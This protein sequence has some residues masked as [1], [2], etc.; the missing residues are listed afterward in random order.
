M[1]RW[2]RRKDINARNRIIE[3]YMPLVAAMVYQIAGRI[4]CVD[5]RISDGNLGL[6]RAVKNFR[7]GH[8]V[9]FGAYA[10]K[11]IRGYVC[12]GLREMKRHRASEEIPAIEPEY[13]APPSAFTLDAKRDKDKIWAAVAE[14]TPNDAAIIRLHYQEGMDL[15]SVAVA[16]GVSRQHAFHAHDEILIRLRLKLPQ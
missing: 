11:Y 13:Q 15:S 1:L 7:I 14:L 5:E 6:F 8:G 12:R 16:L 10:R 9:R 3:S 4:G 2:K